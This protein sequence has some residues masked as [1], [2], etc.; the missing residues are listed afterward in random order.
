MNVTTELAAGMKALP[1]EG[2]NFAQ[3]QGLWRFL[4]NDRV[5][6]EQL[7]QPLLRLAH[8]QVNKQCTH[9]VLSIHDWS[10]INYNNHTSKKDRVQMSH[11]KDLGYD[12]HASLFVSDHNG[13]SLVSP[14]MNMTTKE[15]M[16]CSNHSEIQKK[17][18]H[19]D[20][21]TDKID[22]LEN[23]GFSKPIIHIIDREA[24]SVGHLR[25]W[26]AKGRKW[27]IRV[28]ESSTIQYQGFDVRLS[29]LFTELSYKSKGDVD[30]KGK[31]E[32][33]QVASAEIVLARKAKGKSAQH[34]PTQAIAVKLVVSQVVNNKGEILARWCLLTNISDISDQ[35]L[36]IWYYYRWRIESYFKV[37]KQAGHQLESWEQ[38]T[39]KAIFKR[40]LIVSQAC[41]LAWQIMHLEGEKAES[42]KA[43]L[44]KLSGRQMKWKQRVTL[45]ALLDGLFKLFMLLDVLELYSMDELKEMAKMLPF[46]KQT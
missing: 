42:F 1:D 5:G 10:R 14:I 13:S 40:L 39:G 9:Y 33:L 41:A 36:A 8:D 30:Y 27:L 23:Q 44:V 15:G 32:K 7:S 26:T 24:D 28:K 43:F 31:K 38:E 12:L 45:S 16:L 25:D 20:A 34:Q 35:Q 2:S 22:W 17:K 3:T 29:D 46:A 4:N 11:E 19:L 37:L 6:F 21:L 18:S